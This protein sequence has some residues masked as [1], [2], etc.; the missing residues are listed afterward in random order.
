M[1]LQHSKFIALDSAMCHSCVCGD[2]GVNKLTVL[3]VIQKYIILDNDNNQLCYWFICL[4]RCTRKLPE[5]AVLDPRGAHK[6]EG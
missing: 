4:L 2:V 3:P 6:A 1:A 5:T